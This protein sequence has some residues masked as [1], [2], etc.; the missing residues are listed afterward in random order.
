MSCGK[1]RIKKKNIAAAPA[2]P[3]ALGPF[4]LCSG[5]LLRFLL[6]LLFPSFLYVIFL[7]SAPHDCDIPQAMNIAFPSQKDVMHSQLFF[8]CL[9]AMHS[10]RFTKLVGQV[11]WLPDNQTHL[12]YCISDWQKSWK[13]KFHKSVRNFVACLWTTSILNLS[14]N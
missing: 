2:V 10:H 7:S 8:K 12:E 11:P 6:L 14:S 4:P 3:Y 9:H 13:L 5:F 1:E